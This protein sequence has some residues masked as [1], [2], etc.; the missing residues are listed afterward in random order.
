MKQPHNLKKGD[1]LTFKNLG[2]LDRWESKHEYG[3]GEF[4]LETNEKGFTIEKIIN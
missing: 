3:I 1:K 4:K 2:Q